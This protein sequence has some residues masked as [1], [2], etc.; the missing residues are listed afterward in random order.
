MLQRS[1][2]AAAAAW[3]LSMGVASTEL[4]AAE[5]EPVKRSFAITGQAEPASYLLLAP[6]DG[7]NTKLHPL[8]VY[9]YGRGG[10]IKNNT[11]YNL[12]L[13]SYAKVRQLAAERGYY[14][15]VPELG[16]SHWMGETARRMLDAIVDHAIANEPIDRKRISL[17]GSSMG[18][19]S[20]LAYAIHRPDIVRSVCA[21]FP[22]TDFTQ[23]ASETPTY[24]AS[25]STVY[26][27]NPTQATNA[28]AAT[29]AMQHIDSFKNIPV[30]LIHGNADTIVRTDQSRRL[31][32]ALQAK[33]YP[34]IFHEVDGIGHDD[35]IVE[36]FRREIVDF[37][38]KT[39]GPN[40]KGQ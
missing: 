15:L 6:K 8:I 17:M 31:A 19:G 4:S 35:V 10:S 30:L 26:G 11:T 39:T 22:I 40:A 33:D 13:P 27:G 28:W 5:A 14:I 18:G 9:L 12:G 24:L 36:P 37:F 32:K 2:F 34:V 7:S 21:I 38:D 29:S 20:A 16:E 3:V 25:I 1:F 23:F